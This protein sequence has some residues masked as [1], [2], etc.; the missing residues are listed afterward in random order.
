MYTIVDTLVSTCAGS[1]NL[2][3]RTAADDVRLYLTFTLLLYGTVLLIHLVESFQLLR[4]L[5]YNELSE[6]INKTRMR[7]IPSTGD[8]FYGL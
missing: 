8:S 3:F 2:K 5:V 6:I 4:S 7:N 1:G